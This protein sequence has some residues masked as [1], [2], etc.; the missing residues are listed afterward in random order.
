MGLE[1]DQIMARV[2]PET[3]VQLAKEC[4]SPDS[5]ALFISC[6]A[7]RSVQVIKEIEKS[8]NRPVVTSNQAAAWLASRI[9]NIEPPGA[10]HGLLMSV[11]KKN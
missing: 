6:T 2:A 7:L 8:I 9:S 3:I 10:E 11:P 5:D 4:I 1:D